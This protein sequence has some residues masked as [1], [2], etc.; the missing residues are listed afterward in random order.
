[1]EGALAGAVERHLTMGGGNSGVAPRSLSIRRRRCTRRG[2]ASAPA[3]RNATSFLV[4][5]LHL[6]DSERNPHHLVVRKDPKFINIS[7]F[8]CWS[9]LTWHDGYGKFGAPTRKNPY[10]TTVSVSLELRA[11]LILPVNT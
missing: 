6:A 1:M 3:N 11:C 10:I 5:A 9:L 4:I 8:H 7:D 2:T